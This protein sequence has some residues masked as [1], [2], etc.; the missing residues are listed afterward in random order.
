MFSLMSLPK[1]KLFTRVATVS[2]VSHL[3]RICVNMQI[4]LPKTELLIAK[5]PFSG[6]YSWFKHTKCALSHVYLRVSPLSSVLK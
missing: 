1:S 3:C 5:Q 6:R 4:V 2:F